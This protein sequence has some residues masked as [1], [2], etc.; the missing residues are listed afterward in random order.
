MVIKMSYKET[1]R[2]YW[3]STYFIIGMTLIVLGMF[4]YN[5]LMMTIINMP[6]EQML[7]WLQISSY[8]LIL[9][10]IGSILC[11]YGYYKVIMT[12]D[13][14]DNSDVDTWFCERCNRG[15]T[16]KFEAEEHEEYCNG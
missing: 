1:M 11:A 8:V 10:L 12:D 9:P 14:S 5:I 13:N 7:S 3:K 2:E 4:L 16:T 6:W 15:F